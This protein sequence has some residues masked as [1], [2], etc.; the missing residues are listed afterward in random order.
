MNTD[1]E[2]LVI[3]TQQEI[4][5]EK[6]VAFENGMLFGFVAMSLIFLCLHLCQI[7]F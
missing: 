6:S 1:R 3:C 2:D 7:N 5:E 4:D